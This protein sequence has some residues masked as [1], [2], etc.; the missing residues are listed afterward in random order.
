M[1][2]R[3][4]FVEGWYLKETLLEGNEAKFLGWFH[5]GI[6]ERSLNVCKLKGAFTSYPQIKQNNTK[7]LL[8]VIINRVLQCFCY[9]FLQS[10]TAKPDS[11]VQDV[12][13][14]KMFNVFIQFT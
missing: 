4:S 9:A 1:N 13:D 11:N 10:L 3:R 12:L 7:S 14:N 2:T 5:T 6:I 8:D